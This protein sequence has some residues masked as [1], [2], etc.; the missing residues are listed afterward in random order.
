MNVATIRLISR[1]LFMPAD[2]TVLLPQKLPEGKC[3]VLWLLHGACG[4]HRS[5][6]YSAD[7]DRIVREHSAIIVMP[8]AL[9]SDYGNYQQFGTGYDFASYFF[10]E[11]M[12]FVYATFPASDAPEQNYIEGASM[13]GFGA[14]LL[15]LMHP[16]RFA[17]IGMLGASLRESAFLLPYENSTSEEFRRAALESPKKFPTEYGSPDA[18]IKL[19]EVNVITKYPTIRA[20][21]DS[22]D[23]MWRRFPEVVR[24]GVLPEFYVACG[25]E[26]LFYPATERFMELADSLGVRDR[27]HF[28]IEEGVGHDPAFFD[29]EIVAFAVYFGI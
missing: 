5:Y 20:F 19:K 2:A 25:T 13:G 29:R 26:D 28:V 6:L 12:P 14:A 11:L 16:E 9:N 23:C 10:D 3:P 22:P 8:S 7:L 15:G 4:D 1:V 27:V 18:G 17:A 24:R 21:L